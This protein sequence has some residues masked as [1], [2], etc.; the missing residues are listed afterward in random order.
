MLSGIKVVLANG[1]T[2][3]NGNFKIKQSKIRGVDSSGCRVQEK[4]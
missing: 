2:I 3:P 1:I 4:N